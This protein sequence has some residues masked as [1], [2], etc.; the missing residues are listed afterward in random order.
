M[1]PT[2]TQPG[3]LPLRFVTHSVPRVYSDISEYV[4]LW[5]KCLNLLQDLMVRKP[6]KNVCPVSSHIV[7][8]RDLGIVEMFFDKYETGI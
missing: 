6:F 5:K 7:F 3:P 1:S 4:V 2:H 8:S